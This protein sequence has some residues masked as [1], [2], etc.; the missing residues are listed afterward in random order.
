MQLSREELFDNLSTM[1]Q[2]VLAVI[3]TATEPEMKKTG[4]PFYGKIT[5]VQDLRASVGSW[6]YKNAVNNRRLKEW[7]EALLQDENTPKPEE[8]VPQQRKWGY[9]VTNTPF[10]QHNG[11]YYVE[12]SV[13]DCLRQVYLDDKGNQVSKELLEPYLKKSSD[14][15][16][17]GLDKPVILRDVKLENIVSI[18]HGGVVVEIQGRNDLSPAKLAI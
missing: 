8:F 18:T 2:T 10:V 11:L 12:L 17:Q 3:R 9:R 16:R 15:G 13:H 14:G 6:S 7:K 4:N 5:K 1:D